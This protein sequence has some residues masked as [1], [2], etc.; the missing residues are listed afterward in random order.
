MTNFIKFIARKLLSVGK[1]RNNFCFLRAFYFCKIKNKMKDYNEVTDDTWKN[2]LDSNKRIVYNKNI[3]LPQKKTLK[4][5]LDI[6]RSLAGGSTNLLLNSIK[7]KYNKSELRNLKVLSIGPRAEGEIFNIF[8]HGFELKNIIGLDL[9]SY[10]PL[11]KL[12]DMHHLEFNDEE[13]DVVLMGWC[14]AYSND[15]KKALSE[16]RRVL[17]KNGSLIIGYSVNPTVSDQDQIDE[18]GYL[19]RSPFNQINSLDNL[20]DLGKSLGFKMFYS[21][22]ININTSEKIV[23]G[24]TK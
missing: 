19:I 2:T 8:A 16:V 1:I 3:N 15:K 23:Y 18:R 10:S 9:F 5:I 24:G 4:S 12:G 14:L 21:K 6:G 13:F 20:N 22:I 7:K 11:I 17:A